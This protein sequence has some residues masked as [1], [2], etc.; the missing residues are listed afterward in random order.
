MEYNHCVVYLHGW[1]TKDPRESHIYRR[2]EKIVPRAVQLEAPCYH[3][4]DDEGGI[5][6]TRIS[7]ALEMVRE[8][9]KKL[10]QERKE[11]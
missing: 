6:A 4:S 10:R 7:A 2:L 5:E 1:G 9:I 8:L 11:K 3:P